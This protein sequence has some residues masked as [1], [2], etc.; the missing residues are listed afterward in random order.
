MY[1]SLCLYRILDELNVKIQKDHRENSTLPKIAKTPRREKDEGD[2]KNRRGKDK[3]Q[4]E[5]M[6][7]KVNKEKEKRDKDCGEENTAKTK[8][9]QP[10]KP[11]KTI[12][13]TSELLI[14]TK[15]SKTFGAKVIDNVAKTTVSMK[16]KPGKATGAEL[17][18]EPEISKLTKTPT[19]DSLEASNT[20]TD[21]KDTLVAKTK[22]KVIAPE[23]RGGHLKNTDTNNRESSGMC[24]SCSQH[25]VSSVTEKNVMETWR[26]PKN[27]PRPGFVK[28]HP[29][30]SSSPQDYLKSTIDHAEVMDTNLTQKMGTISNTEYPE[31]AATA[32]KISNQ[33]ETSLT[34]K[35][36]Q[37]L[38]ND[39][40]GVAITTIPSVTKPRKTSTISEHQTDCSTTDAEQRR[41]FEC[42]PR[43]FPTDGEITDVSIATKTLQDSCNISN[44]EIEE[45]HRC[46]KMSPA[47][48]TAANHIVISDASGEDYKENPESSEPCTIH[49]QSTS[50]S[51][52][53]AE[54][55]T[56]STLMPNEVPKTNTSVGT[57][58]PKTLKVSDKENRDNLE[59]SVSIS[60]TTKS[61]ANQISKVSRSSN[62]E[63]K[64]N[65]S[66]AEPN[67]KS[68]KPPHSKSLFGEPKTKHGSL[69]NHTNK[70]IT[71]V[72]LKTQKTTFPTEVRKKRENPERN[73]TTNISTIADSISFTS[74]TTPD[75]EASTRDSV[76]HN[77]D[78]ADV[79]E[80]DFCVPHSSP[81]PPPPPPS[82]TPLL[83]PPSSTPLIPSSSVIST[84]SPA[85]SDHH[86]LGAGFH[87]RTHSLRY[88]RSDIEFMLPGFVLFGLNQSVGNVLG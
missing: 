14:S 31:G 88:L 15:Q 65:S 72:T 82:S 6:V 10:L 83:I 70:S 44:K 81:P 40:I 48:K 75:H 28:S 1:V 51:K 79:K 84:S 36:S 38:S 32:V 56:T 49:Q 73:D 87:P 30:G 26:S 13:N 74:T 68:L 23:P 50:Q 60:V 55:R 4:S 7:E 58:I 54:S 85:S 20:A 24:S 69:N 42:P 11:F 34:L 52:I 5:D 71:T 33:A 57:T 62:I 2:E 46:L 9:K 45:H 19:S 53:T 16:S 29:N 63:Q 25:V 64:N 3:K 76:F 22:S 80:F 66:E 17:R 61:S 35:A 21:R 37:S 39:H 43:G 86:T 59:L 12:R 78:T 67:I 47:T 18:K 27:E 8:G 41:T 77:M